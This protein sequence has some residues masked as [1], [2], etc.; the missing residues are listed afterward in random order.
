MQL[1]RQQHKNADIH[2][3]VPAAS[4]HS[5]CFRRDDNGRYW[6]QRRQGVQRIT[7]TE[8]MKIVKQLGL[9]INRS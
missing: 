8:A 5:L 7:T 9:Q 4:Y 6:L 1:A 3:V 2:V